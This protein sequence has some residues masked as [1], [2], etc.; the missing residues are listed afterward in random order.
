MSARSEMR[1][2]GARRDVPLD[3][4]GIMRILPHRPPFLLVD[5]IL[6]LEP[7]VRAV[8]V[9]SVTIDE[10]H[11]AGHFPGKPI[12][13]GVLILEALAQVGAV[14]ILAAEG[15]EG[16]IPLFAGIDEC[17]FRRPVVPGD[18]LSL[19]LS[20]E[21]VRGRIGIGKGTA[22]VDGETVA[23][24]RLSFALADRTEV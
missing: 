6:E 23:E 9:K 14:A 2:A 5:R 18:L 20:I 3:A 10:P 7:G 4:Q 24:A 17:R 19:E 8:G 21:R 22:R 12:M 15:N 1:E 11:F 16:K 13:P